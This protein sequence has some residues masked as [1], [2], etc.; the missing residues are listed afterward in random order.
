[1]NVI[2]LPIRTGPVIRDVIILWILT[3]LGGLV[4]GVAA[5]DATSSRFLIAVAL[6]NFLLGVV[7]FAISGFLVIGRPWKHL[8]IVAS[9]AWA[10]S[11]PNVF[12]GLSTI[13]RWIFSL[14]F[15][16]II[17]AIGG[18]LSLLLRQLR[19]PRMPDATLHEQY[20]PSP[21]SYHQP[22]A[23]PSTEEEAFYEIVAGELEQQTQKTG[24]WA[25]AFADAGGSPEQARAL[26]IRYRV[27]QL[28]EVRSR[29]QQEHRQTVA[30]VGR[31]RAA[32]GFRRFVFG[33]FGVICGFASLI[34]AVFFFPLFS[35]DTHSDM[36]AVA[37]IM[38]VLSVLFASLTYWCIKSYQK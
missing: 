13:A 5:G 2:T 18:G 19:R 9:A 25:K 37:I 20:V 34:F 27:A 23:P 4:A 10:T 21:Q 11:I 14:P 35:S 15:M 1:M 33:L 36:F 3:A 12:L 32:A 6:S 17:M 31:Q 16:F 38:A 30:K 22:T 24:I 28:A 26:Y 29:E 8:S 7:G